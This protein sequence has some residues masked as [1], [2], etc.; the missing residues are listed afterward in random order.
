[1][2]CGVNWEESGICILRVHRAMIYGPRKP[3]KR[4]DKGFSRRDAEM[5]LDAGYILEVDTRIY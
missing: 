5:E 4:E 1:M 3:G 2:W